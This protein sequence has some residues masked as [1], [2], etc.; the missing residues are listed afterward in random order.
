MAITPTQNPFALFQSWFDEA[1]CNAAITDASAMTLATVDDAGAPDA[2]VV[3]LKDFSEEGFTFY[4]NLGSAKARQLQANATAALCFYWAPLAKQVRIRGRVTRV[5]DTEADAYFK[6]RPRESRIGAWASRQSDPLPSRDALESAFI[7]A[8]LKYDGV[9]VPR[10]SFWSGFRLRPEIIEFWLH[11]DF[12]LHH[13]VRY[14]ITS[15]GEW[16]YGLLNP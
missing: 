15:T 9:E 5:D 4:T 16:E 10:P 14:Q 7:A 1:R 13:R 11:G 2:R 6:S 12:R 8:K 3:L